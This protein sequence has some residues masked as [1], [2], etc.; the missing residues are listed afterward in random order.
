[1]KFKL[2]IELGNDAMQ[3]YEDVVS[4]LIACQQTVA[5]YRKL[6]VGDA[7]KVRDI[8]GNTVGKWEV[9]E[10]KGFEP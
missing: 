3:T 5:E 6:H 7:R 9:V 4:S 2:E 1:M 10:V 8:N